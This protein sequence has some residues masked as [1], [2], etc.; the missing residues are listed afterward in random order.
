[1]DQALPQ[2]SP[3][4][5]PR[6]GY[7]IGRDA[8]ARSDLFVLWPRL[9]IGVHAQATVLQR[10][11]SATIPT[12]ATRGGPFTDLKNCRSTLLKERHLIVTFLKNE[13]R[14]GSRGLWKIQRLIRTDRTSPRRLRTLHRAHLGKGGEAPTPASENAIGQSET[15]A[16]CRAVGRTACASINQLARPVLGAVLFLDTPPKSPINSCLS[17]PKSFRQT[18][19]SRRDG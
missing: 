6:R 5:S 10:P 1:M 7:F 4:V 3:P 14:I 19:A 8:S 11:L 13:G 15:E 9:A 16:N 18:G 2:R 17:L 12:V